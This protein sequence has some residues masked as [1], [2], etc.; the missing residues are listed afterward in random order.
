MEKEEH[1]G[2]LLL[3]ESTEIE[4]K[5]RVKSHKKDMY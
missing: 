3:Q 2:V 4:L 1:Q 5:C